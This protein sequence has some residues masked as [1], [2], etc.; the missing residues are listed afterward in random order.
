MDKTH[1]K[2]HN[3]TTRASYTNILCNVKTIFFTKEGDKKQ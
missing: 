1:K 3:N 2:A